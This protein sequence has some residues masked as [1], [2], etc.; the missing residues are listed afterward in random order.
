MPPAPPSD[1]VRFVCE[2]LGPLGGPGGDVAWRRMFGGYGLYAHGVMFALV[3]W[4]TLYFKVDDRNRPAYEAL[5]LEPFRPDPGKP[6][7][8]SYFPPPESAL[9][10]REELLAW[11][12]PALDAALAAASAKAAKAVKKAKAKA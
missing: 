3:A 7:A 2:A 5:G 12:R 10:D 4:D 6:L 11:A 1:F 9:D 8:M